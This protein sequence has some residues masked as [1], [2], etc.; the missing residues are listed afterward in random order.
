MVKKSLVTLAMVSVL[1]FNSSATANDIKGLITGTTSFIETVPVDNRTAFY[2]GEEVF[3]YT[4][5]DP[6]LHVDAIWVFI[7]D[8]DGQSMKSK[9]AKNIKIP[10]TTKQLYWSSF[11]P[12]KIGKFFF[13]FFRGTVASNYHIASGTFSVSAGPS[14]EYIGP[15]GTCTKIENNIP[16]NVTNNFSQKVTIFIFGFVRIFHKTDFKITIN[17]TGKNFNLEIPGK[18]ARTNGLIFS[19][20]NLPTGEYEYTIFAREN[21]NFVAIENASGHFFIE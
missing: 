12:K 13:K 20:I 1:I 11:V 16:R 3:L 10:G 7:Y 18:T 9:L 14:Y 21:G 8:T 17:T 19:S 2:E 5:L 4:Y 15:V 6:A